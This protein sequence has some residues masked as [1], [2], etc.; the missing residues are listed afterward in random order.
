[1][2]NN[3]N[4]LC[5][6]AY[7]K[8]FKIQ[9]LF[10]EMKPLPSVMQICR[11]RKCKTNGSINVTGTLTLPIINWFTI[12]YIVNFLKYNTKIRTFFFFFPD[13]CHTSNILNAPTSTSWNTLT[14]TSGI[15]RLYCIKLLTSFP[16]PS[17]HYQH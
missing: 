1:M 6:S 5:I 17:Y 8:S 9:K 12:I 16:L 14:L 10:Q 11:K 15:G 13:R 4:Y 3:S 7:A 2:H